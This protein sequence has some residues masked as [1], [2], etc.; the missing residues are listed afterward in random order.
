MIQELPEKCS[1]LIVR[2]ATECC[3][4]SANVF[5]L[6]SRWSSEPFS[7]ADRVVGRLRPGP[8]RI[9][10]AHPVTPDLRVRDDVAWCPPGRHEMFS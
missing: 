6:K 7:S 5:A 8:T 10:R 4:N 9:G 2:I 3:E 1:E